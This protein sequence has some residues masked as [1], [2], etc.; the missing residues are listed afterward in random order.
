M[1][2]RPSQGKEVDA[3]ADLNVNISVMPSVLTAP[4][5][6]R[7]VVPEGT[8]LTIEKPKSIEDFKTSM[9]TL[10][11]DVGEMAISTFIEARDRGVGVIA[12]PLFTSGRRFLQAGFHFS[13]A[14]DLEELSEIKGRTVGVP[15]YWM[16][17][18]VWQRSMLQHDYG[19]AA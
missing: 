2:T 13:K 5:T 6:D 16:S 11:F 17:S 18:S 9:L 14:S 19:V 8:K 7:E 4:I 3:M 15:Q 1:M 10:D 12:L